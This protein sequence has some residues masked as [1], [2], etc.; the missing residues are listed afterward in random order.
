MPFPKPD[1][2]A[3]SSESTLRY[4]RR[5]PFPTLDAPKYPLSGFGSLSEFH[6]C[7]TARLWP[8]IRKDLWHATRPFRGLFPFNV[9][10]ATGSHILQQGP[11]PAG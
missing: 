3:F 10:P 4:P 5:R 2:E 1:A 9:F 7:T 6:P 8:S 11:I